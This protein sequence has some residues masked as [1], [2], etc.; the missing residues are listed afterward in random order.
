MQAKIHMGRRKGAVPAGERVACVL[1]VCLC[2]RGTPVVSRAELPGAWQSADGHR[3]AV[4]L[5]GS[6]LGGPVGGDA[7]GAVWLTSFSA[8]RL[9]AESF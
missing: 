3:V 2:P 1:V 7:E 4:G 6:S 9:L 5:S 8:S